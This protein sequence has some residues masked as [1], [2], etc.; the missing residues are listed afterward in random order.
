MRL[1]SSLL[2][3]VGLFTLAA[4]STDPRDNYVGTYAT[5][6]TISVTPTGASTTNVP[7]TPNLTI[8]EMATANEIQLSF[9]TPACTLVGVVAGDTFTVNPSTCTD[10]NIITDTAGSSCTLTENLSGSGSRGLGTIAVSL[11]DSASTYTC[12]DGTTGTATVTWDVS[13]SD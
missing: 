8:S 7:A 13:G 11:S 12:G 5:T 10:P 3:A 6:T 9:D 2:V 1:H 4:C